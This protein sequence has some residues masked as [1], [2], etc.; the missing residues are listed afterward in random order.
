MGGYVKCE[1]MKY[2]RTN[3]ERFGKTQERLAE[4]G[5]KY[6]GKKKRNKILGRNR[7]NWL[8]ENWKTMGVDEIGEEKWKMIRQIIWG[9][10]GKKWE[11]M[12]I[13]E[14]GEKN[15]EIIGKIIERKWEKWEKMGIDEI[16]EENWGK[17]GKI[18]GKKWEKMGIDEIGQGANWPLAVDGRCSDEWAWCCYYSNM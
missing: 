6:T 3:W 11:N 13:D 4:K 16:L 2:G 5:G 10:W 18:I 1:W 17:I 9:K 14:I 15:W 7:K 8:E 12:G